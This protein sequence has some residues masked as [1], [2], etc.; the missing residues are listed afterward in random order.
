VA[1]VIV[2]VA[3]ALAP[4]VLVA[5]YVFDVAGT[6]SFVL[7]AGALAPLAF[8]IGAGKN[9][10]EHTG[11]GIGGFLADR[12]GDRRHAALPRRV[13]NAAEQGGAIVIARRH[14]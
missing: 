7:S 13:G 8:V 9:I 1:R 12:H 3:I 11:A 14:R 5:D 2:W 4:F 10:A 6:A